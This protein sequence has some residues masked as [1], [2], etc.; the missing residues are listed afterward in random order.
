MPRT[1]NPLG[2]GDGPLVD[3]ARGL[4]LL[5][6][7]AGRPSYRALSARAHY[8]AAALS[9][10][11]AGQ[12]LP[13]LEVTLAYVR[14]CGG[15]VEEWRRRWHE[16]AA[17][18]GPSARSDSAR[19]PYAG[20]APFRTADA[21]RFFGREALVEEVMSRLAAQRVV[22]V[23]GASGT[24]K[25]SLL[26]AGVVPRL[27]DRV[28]VLTPGAHPVRGCLAGLARGADA[29]GTT[30]MTD[31]TGTTDATG[32]TDV[33]GMTDAT[34]ATDATDVAVEPSAGDS[35]ELCAAVRRAEPRDG[36]LVLVVDQFEEVFT[37]CADQGE[38]ERF[39]D[40]LIDAATA[41]GSRCR[42]VLSVRADFY[43]HCVG[44]PRL[45][46]VLRAGQVAVE[47]MTAEELHRVVVQPAVSA[48][49]VVETA[50]V[51]RITADAA[52]RAGVL[53]LV[54]HVLLETWRR[55]R[56]TTLTLRGYEA[57]GGIGHAVAHSAEGAY[58]DLSPGQRDIAKQV[59]L[60]LCAIGGAEDTK[61]RAGRAELDH[62]GDEVR[63][64]LERLAAA[65]LVVLDDDGVEIAHE[66]LIRSWP[67]L[68]DWLAEDRRGLQVHRD[69]TVAAATWRAHDQDEG[70][71]YRGVRLEAAR[72]WAQAHRDVLSVA[73]RDF[74]AASVAAQQ[75]VERTER[76]RTARLRGL[77]ALLS[78]LLLVAVGTTWYAVRAAVV[79]EEQRNA[80]LA[81]KVATQAP[82]LRT[83]DPALAARL[84]L[85]AHRLDPTAETR[86]SLLS[87]VAGRRTTVLTDQAARRAVA[88]GRDGAVLAAAGD[89]R[90]V[91]LW[92]L[93]TAHDPE[94]AAGIAARSD[95]VESLAFDPT[96][97]RLAGVGHDGALGLWDVE[98]PGRPRPLAQ[99]QAHPQA[100]YHLRFSPDGATLITASNDGTAALWDVRDPSTPTRNAVLTGHGVP[101]SWAEFAPDGRTAVTA[102]DDGEVRLWD[103]TDRAR[104]IPT[105]VLK[106]HPSH[107]TS[108]AFSPDGA[109]LLTAGFDAVARLWDLRADGGPREVSKLSGHRDSVQTA[110][111]SPDGRT[112]ITGSWDHTAQLWDVSTASAPVATGTITGHTN[113]V[114]A[115]DFSPDGRVVATA[116]NDGAV[117]LTDVPGRVLGGHTDTVRASAVSADG[118]TAATGGREGVV[119]LWDTTDPD[120]PVG[121][122]LPAAAMG[123]IRSVAMSPTLLAAGDVDGLVRLWDIT[124]PRRAR[125]L[126]DAVRHPATA[127][128]LAFSADGAVLAVGGDDAEH[129]V[130]LWSLRDPT[131]PVVVGRV[132]G[133]TDFVPAL[134]FSPR[135][136]VLA[137]AMSRVV[138]LVDVANPAE[139]RLLAEPAGHGDRVLALAFAPDGRHLVSAGL[140]RTA[141]VW[142]VRDPRSPFHASTLTGHNGAVPAVAYAPGGARVATAGYDRTVRLWD[143]TDPRAPVPWATLSGH[144]DE[145]H[146]AAFFPDGR[147]L[148]TGGRDTTGL[149]WRVDPEDAAREVCVL[150]QPAVPE[151]WADYF[152]DIGAPVPCR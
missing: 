138:R 113:I 105:A 23:V 64:V 128:A 37:L 61:R 63:P 119:R 127:R 96:G 71:L 151:Q 139:P 73:E 99:V 12:K 140:D 124:D 57:A 141:R 121:L 22:V 41:D 21:Q 24:G 146:T 2:D 87:T 88:F 50:L 9:Q 47:P 78:A 114:W 59:F 148:L 147:T 135:G 54:S 36:G 72:S 3:F 17:E 94:P 115:A 142:D 134:A 95:R 82:G 30:D 27:D 144:T 81:H 65:R 68:R 86:G 32:M 117:R 126:P 20:L 51:A 85:A 76:R 123:R 102:S 92:R 48:G 149:L 46:R 14:A 93:P 15:P 103:V 110:R 132:A 4:R 10:A 89:D 91:R 111:F 62:L 6:E 104:P 42:V 28:V 133:Q 122:P 58:A 80:A 55:R 52:G 16:L 19:S 75:H 11:A 74:L 33:A 43:G 60:R 131:R 152:P 101:L 136:D 84:A 130:R 120:R 56:G 143:L 5:R 7:E 116:G 118:R 1:E 45:A 13:S 69:L 29:T 106:A 83:L 125:L 53:P 100:A 98:D 26:R 31:A 67:R 44:H 137:L 66:A 107:V 8:S 108:A 90:V 145:V 25:S 112:A 129:V 150:A 109:L 97:T 70:T 34:D 35:L 18:S 38:R 77:V 39:I 79:T 40:Q 49:C